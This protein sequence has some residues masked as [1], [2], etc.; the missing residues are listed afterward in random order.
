MRGMHAGLPGQRHRDRPRRERRK[1]A[2]RQRLNV[3][4]GRIHG[5]TVLRYHGPRGSLQIL[6][7]AK[8]GSEMNLNDM[9]IE[10]TKKEGL[11]VSISIAQTKEVLRIACLMVFQSPKLLVSMYRNGEKQ[12]IDHI[13]KKK[14]RKTSK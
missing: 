9:A 13:V 10:I 5:A 12:A 3:D 6:S 2:G 4:M 7:P 11:K 8:E 1:N 14:K